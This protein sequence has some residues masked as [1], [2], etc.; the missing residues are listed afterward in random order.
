MKIEPKAIFD[1]YFNQQIL[2]ENTFKIDA[3]YSIIRYNQFKI[4]VAEAGSLT[5][6]KFDF[7]M[8]TGGVKQPVVID[9]SKTFAEHSKPPAKHPKDLFYLMADLHAICNSETSFTTTVDVGRLFSAL[10]SISLLRKG[11]LCFRVMREIAQ[12]G[13][14]TGDRSKYVIQGQIL[15]DHGWVKGTFE[16]NFY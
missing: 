4:L 8:Q 11:F 3:P 13:E 16:P 2:P 9:L 14:C 5:Q 12:P 6:R 7:Y 1:P 10:N 15:N